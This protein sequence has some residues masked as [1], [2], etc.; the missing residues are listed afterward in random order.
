[1]QSRDLGGEIVLLA[2]KTPPEV[3]PTAGSGVT[4]WPCGSPGALQPTQ[5]KDDR[6]AQEGEDALH[7]HIKCGRPDTALDFGSSYTGCRV[8]DSKSC[9][10][11]CT[12]NVIGGF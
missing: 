12:R 6:K 1:M 5:P 7:F 4:P 3:G 9:G 2:P 11:E 8:S 10:G